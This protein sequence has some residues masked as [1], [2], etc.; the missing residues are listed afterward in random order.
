MGLHKPS[1]SF[2]SGPVFFYISDDMDIATD[3]NR[4]QKGFSMDY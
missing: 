1:D 2:F 4:H 3:I